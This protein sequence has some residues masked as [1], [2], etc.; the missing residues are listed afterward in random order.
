M[1]RKLPREETQLALG[2][3]RAAQSPPFP[4][5]EDWRSSQAK[6]HRAK[7]ERAKARPTPGSRGSSGPVPPLPPPAENSFILRAVDESTQPSRPGPANPPDALSPTS[8]KHGRALERAQW[9]QLPVPR[10][11]RW[12]DLGSEGK[13]QT[14]PPRND[15]HDPTVSTTRPPSKAP[16][17]SSRSLDSLLYFQVRG[18]QSPSEG[19][20]TWPVL[21][22]PGV[23]RPMG[24]R[25]LSARQSSPYSLEQQLVVLGLELAQ[26]DL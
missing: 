3:R 15:R 8:R 18:A 12:M 10:A 26:L 1:Q 13:Y 5:G 16:L 22:L 17:F 19:Q 14:Q 7:T 4:R 2:Q 24:S 6:C 20:G 25:S 21:S 11:C 23:Q 9:H